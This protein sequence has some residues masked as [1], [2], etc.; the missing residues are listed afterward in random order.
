MQLFG[1]A[2]TTAGPFQVRD[3]AVIQL[4]QMQLNAD[5]LIA[6]ANL[7]PP[8]VTAQQMRRAIVAAGRK[9]AVEN[10][11]ATAP[12]N[13]QNYWYTSDVFFRDDP[14]L[15]QTATFAGLT[16]TQ[17]DNFFRSAALL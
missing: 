3:D 9:S 15:I 10:A 12:A 4:Q 13:I 5:S 7:I 11:L 14:L 16:A 6:S 17:T 1:S 8:S 2:I